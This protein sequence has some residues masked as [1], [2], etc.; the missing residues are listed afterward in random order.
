MNRLQSAALRLYAAT[1]AD[2]ERSAKMARLVC[3]RESADDTGAIKPCWKPIY[4]PGWLGENLGIAEY[5]SVTHEGGE[6]THEWCEP[7]QQRQKLYEDKSVRRELGN[8]KRALWAACK[9][10]IKENQ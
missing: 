10:K 9:A 7:C 8:A 3:E 6:S 5:P 2:R 1:K 4:I